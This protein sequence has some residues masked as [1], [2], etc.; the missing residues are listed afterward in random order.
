MIHL[1]S[2]LSVLL[3]LTSEAERANCDLID[4]ECLDEKQVFFQL[5]SEVRDPKNSDPGVAAHSRWRWR[6][7]NRRNGRYHGYHS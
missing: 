2:L 3:L 4:A 7:R 5:R 1:L 6:R